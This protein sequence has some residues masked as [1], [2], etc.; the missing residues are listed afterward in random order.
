MQ[1]VKQ[2]AHAI[3]EAFCINYGQLIN[4]YKDIQEHGQV[5]GI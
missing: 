5:Q 2:I 1:T 3:V 4:A